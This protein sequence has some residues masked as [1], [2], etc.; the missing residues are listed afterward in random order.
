MIKKILI[1][2]LIVIFLPSMALCAERS[3]KDKNLS[4]DNIIEKQMEK[5]N[6]MEKKE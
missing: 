3:E 2:A 4:I 5:I 1:I 6:T